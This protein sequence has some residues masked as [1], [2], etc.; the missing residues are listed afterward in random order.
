M[1]VSEADRIY[2]P[3]SRMHNHDEVTSTE[4]ALVLEVYAYYP[5]RCEVISYN[6]KKNL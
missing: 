5:L 2:G 1:P 6:L 4:L 3:K